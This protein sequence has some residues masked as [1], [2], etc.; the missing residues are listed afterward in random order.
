M[1]NLDV[2]H[3][4]VFP[5]KL[6]PKSHLAGP[7]FTLADVTVFPTVATLFRFGWA[8]G[9]TM[10]GQMW[11]AVCHCMWIVSSG[12]VGCLLIA[13][14]NLGSIILYWRTDRASKP[15]GHLT[16]WRTWRDKMIWR[17]SDSLWRRL[18]PACLFGTDCSVCS[19]SSCCWIWYV[20]FSNTGSKLAVWRDQLVHARAPLRRLRRGGHGPV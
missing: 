15:A 13:T 2:F 9:E 20:N 18:N 1:P 3:S 10:L 12:S 11:R 5:F 4:I 6:G 8:R 19:N 14:R 7:S 16:G 17:T